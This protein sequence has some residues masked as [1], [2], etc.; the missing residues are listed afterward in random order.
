M[1]PVAWVVV[2][3]GS[4]DETLAV[5][6]NFAG[7]HSWARAIRSPGATSKEGPLTDGR[8]QGR[9]VVAFTAGVESLDSSPGVV[10]KLDADVSFEDDFFERLLSEFER[11]SRLGIAGGLCEELEGVEWRPQNVTGSHVRGA[12]RA[13]RWSCFRQVMPL[14]EAL[15]W[16]GIDEIKA[17]VLGW[18]VR[19]IRHLP[20]RHHRRVGQRD[21][22]WRAWVGQGAAAH[23][24]GY[25]LTY[26]FL[27]T[28]YHV[29]SDLGAFGMLVGYFDA[30]LKRRPICA[31]SVVRDSL[32]RRQGLRMLPTRLREARGRT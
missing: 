27:R 19:T 2:D 28:L 20:F 7:G 11:D 8:R 21:G 29:R 23:F 4:T 16:D 6:E 24:M 3:D 1:Q 31:D 15:G 9:D 18:N 14:E 13:Y 22:T 26:L 30:M 10:V 5:V 17:E 12:T 32:R 25:R